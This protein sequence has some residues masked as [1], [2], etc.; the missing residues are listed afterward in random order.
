MVRRGSRVQ[1]PEEA[2]AIVCP[3]GTPDP[4]VFNGRDP[5]LN[6]RCARDVLLPGGK[7]SIS[8]DGDSVDWG[9]GD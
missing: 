1:I 7:T 3:A 6:G 5:N 8:V 4:Y 2:P 9:S